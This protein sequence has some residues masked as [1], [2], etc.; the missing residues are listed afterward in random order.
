MMREVL[1]Q[2]VGLTSLAEVWKK[3]T[4]L[5]LPQSKAW[6]VYLRTQLNQTRRENFSACADYFDRITALADEMVI[7][8]KRIYNF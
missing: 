4:D 8:L 3:V 1:T 5:F 6:V 7:R 2:L